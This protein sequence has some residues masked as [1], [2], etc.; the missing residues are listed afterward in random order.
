MD[1]VKQAIC[2]LSV[3]DVAEESSNSSNTYLELM[4]EKLALIKEHIYPHNQTFQSAVLDMC[5]HYIERGIH[6]KAVP[7][8]HFFAVEKDIFLS[9]VDN[10][11]ANNKK[12]SDDTKV[13][14]SL[15]TQFHFLDKWSNPYLCF[16]EDLQTADGSISM[17]HLQVVNKLLSQ[18]NDKIVSWTSLAPSTSTSLSTIG[19]DMQQMGDHLSTLYGNHSRRYMAL[20]SLSIKSASLPEMDVFGNATEAAFG[21]PLEQQLP[22]TTAVLK[23]GISSG[24]DNSAKPQQQKSL[25]TLVDLDDE[26]EIYV[27]GQSSDSDNDSDNADE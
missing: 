11:S 8:F 1:F 18:M 16:L 6:C 10:N 24:N 20:L 12:K 7:W 15:L 23:N 19:S 22:P 5:E 17:S 27:I 25:Q 14:D 2:L 3:V 9:C 13:V 26:L 21:Y 4:E